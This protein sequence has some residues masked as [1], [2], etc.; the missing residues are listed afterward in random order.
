MLKRLDPSDAGAIAIGPPR[1]RPWFSFEAVA[2]LLPLIDILIIL[3]ASV[4]AWISYHWL[5]GESAYALA[6]P[7]DLTAWLGVG[8]LAGSMYSLWMHSSG[9]Y[10][11]R[12]CL[13]A[14]LEIGQILRAWAFSA[15]MLALMAFLLKVG[16]SFSRGSFLTFLLVAP[17]GLLAWRAAT[18]PMLR[19][20]IENGSI[21]RRNVV[22]IGE[23]AELD[24]LDPQQFLNFFGVVDARRFTLNDYRELSAD[25][26]A[27]L[28]AAADF[29][30]SNDSDEILLALPWRDANAVEA[31]RN[32]LRTLPIPVRLLPDRSLR[33]ITSYPSFA[34]SLQVT[35]LVELQAA[36][37]PSGDGS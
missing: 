3:V 18:K 25:D 1:E 15:L 22:L 33:S 24:S 2:S 14:R 12:L 32:E 27:V 37:F 20:W 8:M 4:V 16:A 7:P 11:I 13:Q 26:T 35:F 6:V 36:P 9:H 19:R 5:S 28:K 30:R 17:A 29:V 31:I 21:G 23:S 10:D 34:S